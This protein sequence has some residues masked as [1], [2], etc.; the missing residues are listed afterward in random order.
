[1]HTVAHGIQHGVGQCVGHR[2]LFCFGLDLFSSVNGSL[3]R[4]DRLGIKFMFAVFTGV[5]WIAVDSTRWAQTYPFTVVAM[6][7]VIGATDGF[8]VRTF[9]SL[10]RRTLPARS[11]HA[12][13]GG[14]RQR[15]SNRTAN[16]ANV[17]TVRFCRM[18]RHAGNVG[19]GERFFGGS[20][21]AVRR[22]S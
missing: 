21:R 16:R 1:M 20:G 8:A 22:E 3:G 12:K 5:G 6:A 17:T 10:T 15:R 19:R 2:Q 13:G 14:R 9:G 7:A 18:F 4:R 11:T